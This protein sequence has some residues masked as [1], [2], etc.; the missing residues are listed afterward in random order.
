ME[1]KVLCLVAR[2]KAVPRRQRYYVLIISG[3][4]PLPTDLAYPGESQ[5]AGRVTSA[6]GMRL[7]D[8][9]NRLPRKVWTIWFGEFQPQEQSFARLT[10]AFLRT[11]PG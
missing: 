3:K 5:H 10:A 9:Q 1:K 6:L 11:V 7:F 8:N 2:S 4:P